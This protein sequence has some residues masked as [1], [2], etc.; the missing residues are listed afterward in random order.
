[1]HKFKEC[2]YLNYLNVIL[3]RFSRETIF[4]FKFFFI[5][6]SGTFEQIANYICKSCHSF[7]GSIRTNFSQQYMVIMSLHSGTCPFF[8]MYSQVLCTL[9]LLEGWRKTPRCPKGLLLALCLGSLLTGLG[10][11][12]VFGALNLDQ[13]HAKQYPICCIITPALLKNMFFGDCN[14]F[15][16]YILKFHIPLQHLLSIHTPSLTNNQPKFYG[17]CFKI[18]SCFKEKVNVIKQYSRLSNCLIV[19]QRLF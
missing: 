11:N 1:M 10:V 15:T 5:I 4:R 6:C 14:P 19:G 3:Q 12:R 17:H 9:Y 2:H 13:P 18:I 8:F 16:D 7:K